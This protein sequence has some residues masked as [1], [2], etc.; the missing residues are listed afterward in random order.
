MRIFY[1]LTT[2]LIAAMFAACGGGGGSP[3]LSSGSASVFKVSA[4]ATLTLQTGSS[5]QYAVTGGVKPYSVFSTDP[6]VVVGWL[7]GDD[8]VAIGSV[9]GG[10]ATITVADRQGTKFDITITAGAGTTFFTTTPTALTIPVGAVG[11]RTFNLGGGAP[12]YSAT[13]SNSSIATATVSGSS[14]LITGLKA[15]ATTATISFFDSTGAPVLSSNVTVESSS[16]LPL[17]LNPTSATAFV[18][19]RVVSKI[20][21]GTPPYRVIVAIPDA[22]N[23]TIQN[24]DELNMTILRVVSPVTITVLDA[25]DKAVVFSMTGILGTNGFRLSPAAVTIAENETQPITLT[26]YG[27]SATGTSKVFSSNTGLL[28]ASVNGNIVTVA[29]LGYSAGSPAVAASAGPPQVFA[30]P[31]VPGSCVTS[32]TKVTITLVDG[33]GAIGTTE[34]TILNSVTSGSVCIPP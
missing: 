7:I 11:A 16:S 18:S 22:I 23:A 28:T 26:V 6:A 32:D 21:G 24:Q 31:S 10:K 29:R 25:A 20:T 30:S 17:A 4:P 15:S 14:V 19:D 1:Y 8:V 12:P 9:V 27:A 33:I 13:S 34:V 3:G 2:L 5:Q